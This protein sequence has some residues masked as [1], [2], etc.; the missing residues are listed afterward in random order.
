MK[1]NQNMD[2]KI[3]NSRWGFDKEMAK[4]AVFL[5]R[6]DEFHSQL[7]LNLR[8]SDIGLQTSETRLLQNYSRIRVAKE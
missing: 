7:F 5:T 8:K 6:I 4:F 3:S 2:S 1:T